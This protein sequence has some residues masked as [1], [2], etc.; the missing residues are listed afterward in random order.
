MRSCSCP[1]AP[2][3]GARPVPPA[4]RRPRH[5]RPVEPAVG[6]EPTTTDYK[7]ARF[8]RHAQV[9]SSAC[10]GP[11]AC[12]QSVSDRSSQHA[13][14]RRRTRTDYL[15][16]RC[17]RGPRA[18]T[19]SARQVVAD[20]T[21]RPARRG[22][23]ARRAGAG[24]LP[25]ARGQ[26]RP[27]ARGA[28]RAARGARRAARRRGAARAVAEHR[29]LPGRTNRT[30]PQHSHQPH[31]RVSTPGATRWRKSPPT[32]AGASSCTPRSA[33]C[34]RADPS[35]R[36][37]SALAEAPPRIRPMLYLAAYQGLRAVEIAGLT[38]ENIHDLDDPPHPVVLGKGNKERVLPLAPRE[39]FRPR[40]SPRRRARPRPGPDR[41]GL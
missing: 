41:P 6:F 25:A 20:Q 10:P 35:P 13:R 11:A 15:S 22:R 2:R 21:A 37:S 32:T 14:H 8:G 16:G 4:R 5:A 1:A 34:Y 27:G 29:A 38:R 18:R 36:R 9:A 12:A 23:V 33:G 7:V 30:Q 40:R 39:A 31:P 26:G 19:S 17:P 3:D 24:H 28:R